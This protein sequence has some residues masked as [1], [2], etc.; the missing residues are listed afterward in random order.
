VNFDPN[1]AK[2]V[3]EIFQEFGANRQILIFTFHPSTIEYFGRSS[4]NLIE[5]KPALDGQFVRLLQ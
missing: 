1:R 2:K 4:I 5:L 3:A